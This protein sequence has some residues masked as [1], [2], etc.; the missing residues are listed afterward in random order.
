MEA[1]KGQSTS[2]L[3][4]RTACSEYPPLP[5]NGQGH[6]FVCSHLTVCV[7][8]CAPS[9]GRRERRLGAELSVD[10]AVTKEPL[11][12]HQRLQAQRKEVRG[13]LTPGGPTPESPFYS[14]S[15]SPERGRPP[16]VPD[17]GGPPSKESSL[18]HSVVNQLSR[19]GEL[20]TD[21]RSGASTYAC[22]P[23]RLPED[24]WDSIGPRALLKS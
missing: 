10:G 17:R 4:K 12:S 8:H 5:G 9:V 11:V 21:S 16:G 7:G 19:D 6:V 14:S 13:P 3:E 22:G 20:R 15:Q 2:T 1:S 23:R 24:R 18:L